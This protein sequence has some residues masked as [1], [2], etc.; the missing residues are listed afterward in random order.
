MT[1]TSPTIGTLTCPHCGA[2]QRAEIP[3]DRCVPFYVCASCDKTVQA[4]AGDCCVF[5]SY[6]DRKCPVGHE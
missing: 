4:K 6:G 3:Q 2:T 5:C 1:A